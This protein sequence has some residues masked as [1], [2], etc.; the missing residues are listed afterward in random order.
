MDRVGVFVDAGYVFAQGSTLLSGRKLQR[1]EVLLDGKKLVEALGEF[2]RAVSGLPL[3]RIYWYDGTSTGPTPQHLSL[4]YLAGVKLRLGFVN[5]MGV[6][7]GVDSLIVT[8]MIA[9][10]RNGAIAEAVLVSGD[11]DLRVGVQQAQENGVRVHLV[12]IKPA[13]GS[14]SMFLL[15]EADA[16]YEWG[17]AEVCP[18]LSLRESKPPIEVSETPL[19]SATSSADPGTVLLAVAN[20]VAAGVEI[21]QLRALLASARESGTVPKDLHAKLLTKTRKTLGRDLDSKEKREVRRLFLEACES[22]DL[23]ATGPASDAG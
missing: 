11:E 16:T 23:A 17:D 19:V 7:K 6:Q 15:Q 14:Q 9:L 3:L 1:S 5:T 21:S 18:F 20:D 22:L 4:A 13:R 2:A 12:G 8:D 10:A